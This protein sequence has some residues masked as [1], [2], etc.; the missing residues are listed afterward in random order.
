MIVTDLV[1]SHSGCCVQSEQGV[2]T[3][4][5]RAEHGCC[6][7]HAQNCPPSIRYRGQS[8]LGLL[9]EVE[10]DLSARSTLPIVLPV[11][12]L[13]CSSGLV[14]GEVG[15]VHAPRLLIPEGLR[16]SARSDSKYAQREVVVEVRQPLIYPA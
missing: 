15:E 10:V 6:D 5:G 14:E 13:P 3:S 1:D 11:C 16:L 12:Y 9:E 4:W 7:S 8:A 2:R